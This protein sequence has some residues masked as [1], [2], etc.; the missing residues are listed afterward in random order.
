MTNT[1]SESEIEQVEDLRYTGWKKGFWR[2]ESSPERPASGATLSLLSLG[3]IY[4]YLSK[5]ESCRVKLK[6]VTLLPIWN[7]ID[8]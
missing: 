6:F 5:I 7:Y 2:K 8:R 1:F 3:A 4:L